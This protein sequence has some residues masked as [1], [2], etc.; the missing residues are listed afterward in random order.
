MDEVLNIIEA[1]GDMPG[2]VLIADPDGLA[3]I[4]G[5]WDGD[6]FIDPLPPM[7]T[8]ADYE[9]A[10]Q[11]HLDTSASKRGYGDNRTS[12]AVS[13]VTYD[14]DPNP[15]FSSDAA[16]FKAWRSAVWTH[17]YEVLSAVESG[18]RVAPSIDALMAELPVLDWAI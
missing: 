1:E 5:K 17:C 6:K 8:I 14:N 11:D 12:P 10:I 18:G 15:R 4:G 2:L 9:K 7:L 3:R 13:I 16:I